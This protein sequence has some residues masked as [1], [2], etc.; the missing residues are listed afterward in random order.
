MLEAWK[1]GGAKAMRLDQFAALKLADLAANS[2]RR[3]P[4]E[5]ARGEGAVVWRGGRRLISFS[6]N[7]YLNLSTN[8]EIIEAA[9]AATRR[10]GVG[11]GASRA[12]TGDHPLYRN[13]EERLARLKGAEACL[14][15]GSGYL[16]NIGIIPALLGEA[17]VVFVDELAHAC[18]RAGAS[19][20]RAEAIVF[21]HNDTRATRPV[22]GAPPP[23]LPP[24]LD[25][26]RRGVFDGRRSGAGGRAGRAGTGPM[27][28][29]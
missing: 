19:L 21:P 22:D 13:L 25:R 26:D 7:D 18:I 3:E 2:L 16:A 12:V 23:P 24:R 11:A 20:S 4:V 14:V 5:T 10:Y 29:G 27:T 9:V 8:P 28:P 17:D 15:F 6:C 1:G